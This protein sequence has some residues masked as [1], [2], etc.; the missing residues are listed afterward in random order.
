MDAA[1]QVVRSVLAGA[2]FFK[3]EQCLIKLLA[4]QILLDA[5]RLSICHQAQAVAGGGRLFAD[6]AADGSVRSD[7]GGEDDALSF[8]SSR[9]AA[10][11]RVE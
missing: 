4:G 3:D 11:Y 5:L 7:A 1:K 2:A 6:Q 8:L 9:D 10:L